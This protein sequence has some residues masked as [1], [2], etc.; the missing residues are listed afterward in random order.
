VTPAAPNSKSRAG[1][2]APLVE[3]VVCTLFAGAVLDGGVIASAVAYLSIAFWIGAVTVWLRRSELTRSDKLYLQYGLP[4]I[5]L[6]GVPLYLV[7][8]TRRGAI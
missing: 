4:V 2:I 1:L 7:V 8:W 3:Q 5:L 6:L